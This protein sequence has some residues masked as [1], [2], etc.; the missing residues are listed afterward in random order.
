MTTPIHRIQT[1]HPVP[2]ERLPDADISVIVRF[3]NGAITQASVEDDGTWILEDGLELSPETQ[4]DTYGTVTHW[5]DA[6]DPT[7]DQP[8][9][10][11]VIRRLINDC[12][13]KVI[14][15]G[16]RMDEAITSALKT[17]AKATGETK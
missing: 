14:G 12:G 16:G 15:H 2:G 8:D 7:D 5:A 4:G 6:T 1:W 13:L 9:A 17:I 11:E 10:I 3:A